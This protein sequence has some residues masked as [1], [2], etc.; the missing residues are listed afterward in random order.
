MVSSV[1]LS[2]PP[3]CVCTT[4]THTHKP[5]TKKWINCSFIHLTHCIGGVRRYL[6]TLEYWSA[7]SQA[8]AEIWAQAKEAFIFSQFLMLTIIN[9]LFHHK[10]SWFSVHTHMC[11][12]FMVVEWWL[13]P[14]PPASFSPTLIPLPKQVLRGQRLDFV[15]YF[16]IIFLSNHL[17]SVKLGYTPNFTFIWNCLKTLCGVG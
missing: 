1:I 16:Q 5:G 6:F 13:N 10:G 3:P 9:Q 7:I 17:V 12:R 11:Y 2:L 15:L 14:F 4:T 8:Q